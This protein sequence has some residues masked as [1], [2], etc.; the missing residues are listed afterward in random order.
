[1]YYRLGWW[2]IPIKRKGDGS[3]GDGK[4]PSHLKAWQTLRLDEAAIPKHFGAGDNCG[5][6]LGAESG[7][8]TDVDLDCPESVRI[9]H[10]LLPPTTMRHGRAH[11][12]CSHWWYRC[13]DLSGTLKLLD[14]EDGACLIEVRYGDKRGLQTVVPPSV[15]VAS[16]DQLVW[17]SRK[18]GGILDGID[19]ALDVLQPQQVG[20]A[21]LIGAA[22]SVALC[23][24]LAR[25]MPPEGQHEWG[26]ALCGYFGRYLKPELAL[27]LVRAVLLAGQREA[28]FDEFKR[29]LDDAVRRLADNQPVQGAHTLAEFIGEK[30][31]KKLGEWLGVRDT[32][33]SQLSLQGTGGQGGITARDGGAPDDGGKPVK[34]RTGVNPYRYELS[35][36]LRLTDE[37]NAQRFLK[38][39]AAR[40]LHC[41]LLGGW[42]VWDEADGRWRLDTSNRSVEL[43]RTCATAMSGQALGLSADV[44]VKLPDGCEVSIPRADARALSCHWASATLTQSRLESMLA[45][46]ASDRRI[47]VEPDDLD[48]DPFLL[49]VQNYT[50]RLGEPTPTDPGLCGPPGPHD[51]G[52]RITKL[53]PVAF[54]PDAGCERWVQFLD[55]IFD[56]DAAL[57]EFM[58]RLA[59]YVLF[60]GNPEQVI[61]FLWGTGANGKSTFL[62]T[63]AELLGDYAATTSSETV[64]AREGGSNNQIYALA[65]LKGARL[66]TISETDEG[67]RLAEGLVKVM[68]GGEKITARFS[69]GNFFDYAPE[70]LPVV[71]TNHMPE[72]RNVD[73]A[74]RRRVLL[75]PFRVTI[76]AEERDPQLK[77]KLR[78]EL[79]GILNWALSGLLDYHERVQEG[80]SGLAP[81]DAVRSATAEYFEAQD[82]IGPFI[83][84]R[85]LLSA[86]FRCTKAELYRAYGKYCEESGA[87]TLKQTRFGGMVKR[88]LSEHYNLPPDKVESKSGSVRWWEGIALGSGYAPEPAP[89]G[90]Y[91]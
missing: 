18:G 8:L 59:G 6:L 55:K 68:T 44:P 60:G 84:E 76:P 52:L 2:P 10:L 24:M 89:G 37:G 91:G 23:A 19:A 40:V 75:V 35:L 73:E 16:G 70:F 83:E 78:A 79:P 12:G 86:S 9:A 31:T 27:N 62:E 41:A 61:A 87:W 48:A 66:V 15:H 33:A 77:A 22:Q 39:N 45:L 1:V 34:G 30:R 65:R 50:L 3:P 32:R 82:P 5:L 53:S 43:A 13:P 80:K 67:Q 20:K 28:R 42:Y 51:P 71:A 7:H 57:V 26:T 38:L 36:L 69:H 49:N 63:L 25:A 14:P 90:L 4:A 85:C 29:L 74:I 58:Q 81:P 88:V 21:Q 56:H 46:S 47:A 17:I 11:A 54:D 64:L 72:L